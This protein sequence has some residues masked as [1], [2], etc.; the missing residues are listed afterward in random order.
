MEKLA[1][2]SNRYCYIREEG[3]DEGSF[4]L[5]DDRWPILKN[6]LKKHNRIDIKVKKP[7]HG[8]PAPLFRIKNPMELLNHSLPETIK[9]LDDILK[10]PS[11]I[12]APN[13]TEPPPERRLL[14]LI[15]KEFASLNQNFLPH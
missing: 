9:I 12:K 5:K 7:M 10:T 4:L 6:I 11:N 13:M 2:R 15:N 3:D 14:S 1:R 8:R